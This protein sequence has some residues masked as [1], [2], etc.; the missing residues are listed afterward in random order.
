MLTRR[1][2]H[3]CDLSRSRSQLDAGVVR[4]VQRT[5]WSSVGTSVHSGCR[6]R[7]PLCAL[8]GS[9]H[10]GVERCLA[11]SVSRL[12]G[13]RVKSRVLRGASP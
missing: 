5:L 13:P 3:L 2:L 6:S 10:P 7:W 8:E 4:T 9:R 1:V 11:P 12:W